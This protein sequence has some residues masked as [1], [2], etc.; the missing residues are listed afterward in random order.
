M[1]WGLKWEWF[2]GI[3]L[4]FHLESSS[5][6]GGEFFA[7]Y[8][9]RHIWSMVVVFNVIFALLEVLEFVGVFVGG[10][11]FFFSETIDRFSIE[12]TFARIVQFLASFF[13]TSDISPFESAI[14]EFC[15]RI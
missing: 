9:F 8:Q 4:V 5:C 13:Q 10:F 7:F 12:L 14:F 1:H 11:R 2:N 3:E 6:S 15:V